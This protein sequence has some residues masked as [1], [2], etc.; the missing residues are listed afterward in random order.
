M[1]SNCDEIGRGDV[2]ERTADACLRAGQ[3][4]TLS[5]DR[6][7]AALE[8]THTNTRADGAAG[9]IGFQSYSILLRRMLPS[10]DRLP[11]NCWRIGSG[12]YN[13]SS[14]LVNT[15]VLRKRLRSARASR[16][17]SV[18]GLPASHPKERH[19]HDQLSIIS[20]LFT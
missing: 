19:C 13:G 18:S 2:C 10:K 1:A 20:A 6:G 8:R 12:D 16:R 14:S 17:L 15:R 11:T 5:D 3:P 4:R 7:T 9:G